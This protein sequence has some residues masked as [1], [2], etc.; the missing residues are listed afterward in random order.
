MMALDG[1]FGSLDQ[2]DDCIY[3]WARPGGVQIINRVEVV[4]IPERT[5][6][7]ASMWIV[8]TR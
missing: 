1:M 8:L 3:G 7:N 4:V 2:T 6:C 5:N